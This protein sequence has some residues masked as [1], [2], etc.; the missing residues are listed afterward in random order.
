MSQQ[1]G[2]SQATHYSK[3]SSKQEFPQKDYTKFA[4][5]DEQKFLK[6]NGIGFKKK[7]PVKK[8]AADKEVDPKVQEQLIKAKLKK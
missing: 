2:Q 1:S 4:E 5:E 3:L 7:K 6:E 8:I